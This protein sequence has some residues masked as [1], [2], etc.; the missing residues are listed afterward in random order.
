MLI[1]NILAK[2][3]TTAGMV[4][5]ISIMVALYSAYDKGLYLAVNTVVMGG[6]LALMALG[7]ALVFGV[8]N[9]AMF[10]HGEFFM[11]GS[12]SAFYIFPPIH[13]YLVENPNAFLS[14]IA[15]L[16]AILGALL[17]GMVVGVIVEKLV[18]SPLRKRST[19]NWVM[20]SFLLTV[21]LSVI[22]I[23][24]HQLV[25][26]TESK[27][28][29]RYW[30]GRPLNIY[31]VYIARDRIITL[32]LSGI[33]VLLFWLF[34]KYS[35]TGRSIRAV[36]QDEK[37]AL[38]VGINLTGIQML[39]MSLSCGLAAY[40]GACLLFLYPSYPT[41]GIEPLYLA[42]FVVILAG[43]GNIM[44]AVVCAFI[45]SLLKVVTEAYVGS[46]WEYIVPSALIMLMLVFKPSGIFG[47]AVRG[48]HE[49]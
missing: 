36:S 27:T 29:V 26:G 10:A 45:V 37:G 25:F 42:W 18:F 32:F 1:K 7:L 20:N 19:D 12:L 49:Q 9:V 6:M 35:R 46:G 28:I 30:S 5:T 11:I 34:I 4:V 14:M 39:T 15:P 17:I 16:I 40:A 8:M 3:T 13:E 2:S 44:G 21:G 31:D 22:L 43:L 23:N 33:A 47:S 24:G 48:V 38:I 41:V